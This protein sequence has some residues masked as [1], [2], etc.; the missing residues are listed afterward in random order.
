MGSSSQ[1]KQYEKLDHETSMIPVRTSM[2]NKMRMC[3]YLREFFAI[4]ADEL[5][6]VSERRL[7]FRADIVED[8][9]VACL[10]QSR[11]DRS[12]DLWCHLGKIAA[13]VMLFQDED[14]AVRVCDCSSD[15]CTNVVVTVYGCCRKESSLSTEEMR[16]CPARVISRLS[17]CRVISESYDDRS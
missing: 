3:G 4:L 11:V 12:K 6:L 2:R 9:A 13:V 10:R 5:N 17:R 16:L 1:S 15:G 7:G 14:E 8:V